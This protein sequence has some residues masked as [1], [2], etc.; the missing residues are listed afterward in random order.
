MSRAARLA[1]GAAVFVVLVLASACVYYPV[2]SDVGGTRIQPANGRIVR[3]P[4]GAAAFYV[5]LN[6]TGKFGDVLT[7]VTTPVAR[8]AEIV[9]PTGAPL[10]TLEIPGVS[11]VR[12]GPGSPHVLLS[13][14][15]RPLTSGEVIIVTLLFRKLGGLGIV[16][17]V[18]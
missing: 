10:P 1:G 2:I 18:E 4:T 13:D 9:S 8:R 11:V 6:S 15:T 3:Q 17:V 7:G 5:E 12:F 14:L 16:S